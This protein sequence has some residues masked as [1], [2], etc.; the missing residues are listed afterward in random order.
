LTLLPLSA[1]TGSLLGPLVG[2]FLVSADKPTALFARYPY[3]APNICVGGVHFIVALLAFFLLNET[4][5]PGLR[6]QKLP[7]TPSRHIL[8]RCHNNFGE[9]QQI[10]ETSPL[11]F[12]D[13]NAGEPQPPRSRSLPFRDIWTSN[14]IRTMFAQFI[15]SGHLGTFASLWAIFLSLPTQPLS[16][17]HL[18]F[19][20]SG[21]LGLQPSSVG[22]AMSVFGFVGIVLQILVYPNLQERWGAIRVWRGSLCVFPVLYTIAPFC[23]IVASIGQKN[24]TEVNAEGVIPALKWAGIIFILVLFAAG[25]TG[26]VPATSLLINDCTPHS[27][28]R[29]TVHSAG[30]IVSNL[31]RAVFPPIA[32]AVLGYGLELGAVGVGFWFIAVLAVLSCLASIRVGEG[33]NGEEPTE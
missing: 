6:E 19:H 33:N 1:N 27:S 3:A 22:I 4:L 31:S 16:K 15:V 17:Q 21:G 11:L 20:F 2:G 29:A 7:Q 24:E 23:A 8:A 14:V 13:S 10:N 25:R 12:H 28:A 18:P 26:V 9:G 5:D 30:V 32:L